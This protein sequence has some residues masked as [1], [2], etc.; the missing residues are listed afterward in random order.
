MKSQLIFIHRL[1]EKPSHDLSLQLFNDIV[2]PATSAKYLGVEFDEKLN[3][4]KH[5]KEIVKKA[6]ARLNIFKLLV[7][8]GVGN[9]ALLRLYK[10]YVRPL[11]EYGSIAFLPSNTTR[12]QRLQNDFIRLTLRLPSYIRTDLIH[13]AAGLDKVKDRLLELNKRLM[14]KMHE[15]EGVRQITEQSR[16]VIPLNNYLSP[17]DK[18]ME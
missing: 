11:F 16:E 10:T 7:K 9:G 3:F 8:N 5:F 4:D 12:L 6:A 2:R 13:E 17:L 15:L 18:L 14:M 1:Q